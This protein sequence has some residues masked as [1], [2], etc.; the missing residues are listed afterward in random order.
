MRPHVGWDTSG[1]LSEESSSKE[2]GI[3]IPTSTRGRTQGYVPVDRD[4]TE[5]AGLMGIATHGDNT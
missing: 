3:T 4:T 5:D 1:A 2:D